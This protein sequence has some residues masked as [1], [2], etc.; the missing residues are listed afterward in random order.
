MSITTYAELRTAISNWL[1][2]RTDLEARIPEFINLFE[3][4]L[5]RRL[6][7]R[8]TRSTTNITP[9]SGS[10]TLPTDLLYIIR[11]T[12][13]GSTRVD[14]TYEHPS[15][16]QLAYPTSASG[17]PTVYTVEGTTLKVR[18]VDDTALEVL[19]A[20]RTAAL[21]S[22]VGTIFTKHP[23]LYLYGSL[24][25]AEGFLVN[26]ERMA[27]WKALRDEAFDE[28][29]RADFRYRGPMQVRLVQ[30]TP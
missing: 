7:I 22:A 4:K 28:I 9:S 17:T 29:L 23:D 19:Y 20:A 13:T 1:G 12:W 18:P 24:C 27:T 5:S 15:Y 25:E 8:E 30:H 21:S 14:L 3:A 2:E 10:A 6:G 26:D 16:L 11:V